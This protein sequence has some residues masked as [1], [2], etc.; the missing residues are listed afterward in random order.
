[1]RH[2]PDHVRALEKVRCCNSL[3]RIVLTNHGRLTLLD[4]DED[5]DA[6]MEMLRALNPDLRCR[7]HEVLWWWRWLTA[8]D[9]CDRPAE[10]HALPRWVNE[11][12]QY[13]S[14][15]NKGRWNESRS[16]EL[17][18]IS[19]KYALRQ[20]P[21]ELRPWGQ[22]ALKVKE[23]RERHAGYET[24]P[25][26]VFADCVAT[27]DSCWEK[28]QEQTISDLG[29]GLYGAQEV[30]WQ[31]ALT[32]AKCG[33]KPAFG[34]YRRWVRG[35]SE[36]RSWSNNQPKKR[37]EVEALSLFQA[38]IKQRTG[39]WHQYFQNNLCQGVHSMRR[40]Q[41]HV[42]GKPF[43]SLGKDARVRDDVKGVFIIDAPPVEIPA[44][45]DVSFPVQ[46]HHAGLNRR[47]NAGKVVSVFAWALVTR[48]AGE[49]KI[50]PLGDNW[51]NALDGNGWIDWL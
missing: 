3:H 32:A 21:T 51:Y 48:S 25:R 18:K 6:G 43:A 28:G 9:P 8:E 46:V 4:H 35:L 22:L 2:T 10:E 38:R 5:T 50:R 12:R 29:Y 13:E 20:L 16:M 14:V 44:Q 47:S 31:D 30:L 27:L 17:R 23:K 19:V 39:K 15:K 42:A 49:W 37:S 45:G 1:M 24:P 11:E 40:W 41:T 33:V 7:C 36:N 26:A 34:K